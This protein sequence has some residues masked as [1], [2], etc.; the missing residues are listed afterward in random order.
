M[1]VL[2]LLLG[3]GIGRYRSPILPA[4]PY[5][6]TRRAVTSRTPA[7]VERC[8]YGS[9]VLSWKWKWNNRFA[10]VSPVLITTFL[11]NRKTVRWLTIASD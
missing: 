7:I 5:T 1:F 3:V 10:G 4:V 8:S 9:S 2:L 6:A 11:D